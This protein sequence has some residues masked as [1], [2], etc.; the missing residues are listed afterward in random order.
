ME[1]RAIGD[2]LRRHDLE[3]WL[4]ESELGGGDAWDQKIRRQIR[5]CDYFMAVISAHTEARHE[6]YFRR[7][8][9][10]AVDRTLDMA[11]D[12]LFLLPVAID[13]TDQAGARVP[14]KFLTVQWLRL[15]GGVATAAL[16]S[17]CAR[18]VSGRPPDAPAMR[19]AARANGA[20]APG[21]N[22]SLPDFP[23]EEPGQRVKFWTQVLGWALRS[24]WMMFMRVPRWIRIIVYLWVVGTLLS[25]GCSSTR[26]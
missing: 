4:D 23:R 5:E 6:G 19:T 15:P 26:P 22:R 25:R 1:A 24:A 16:D 8:W 12:H 17:L 14:E 11:D 10:L 7:E 9:R 13:D 21:A 20:H 18:L 2:A 3:V